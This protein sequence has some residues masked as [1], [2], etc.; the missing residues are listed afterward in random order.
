MVGLG[1]IRKAMMVGL[2]LSM[3]SII[4]SEAGP[5]CLTQWECHMIKLRVHVRAGDRRMWVLG[6]VIH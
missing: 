6:D 4:L 2:S 5:G 3:L 1:S